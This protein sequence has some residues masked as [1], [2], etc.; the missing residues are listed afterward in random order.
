MHHK[1]PSAMARAHYCQVSSHFHPCNSWNGCFRVTQSSNFGNRNSGTTIF[2]VRNF[3]CAVFHVTGNLEFCNS[4]FSPRWR[5]GI[6]FTDPLES[7]RTQR[8][9]TFHFS[10]FRLFFQ[11]QF[12]WQAPRCA[13]S[14]S[15]FSCN[16]WWE[17]YFCCKQ[18][19]YISYAVLNIKR[20]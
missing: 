20:H 11:K 15:K 3:P 6:R 13:W 5:F 18:M 2:V 9:L 1:K 10:G 16:F 7:K 4:K 17:N 8:F 14:S 19:N 12:A